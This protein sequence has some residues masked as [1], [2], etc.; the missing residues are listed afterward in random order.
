MTIPIQCDACGKRYRVVEE[1][2]GRR[3]KCKGCGRTLRVPHP[4]ED[5]PEAE[6]ADPSAADAEYSESGQP[7]YRHA[8]REKE[9]RLAQGNEETI[10]AITNHVETHLGAVASVFHEIVSDLVHVDVFYVSATDD[11]PYHTL[12][13]SGM[14]DL[15]MTVPEGAEEFR[16]AELLLSLPPSWPLTQEDFEDERN[17]WPIRWLKMLARLPHEYDTWLGYG[18]TIPNGD[19]PR[20][21]A[22]DTKLCCQLLLLPALVPADFLTLQTA[23]RTIHFYALVPLYREEME[24]KLRHGTEELEE[25]LRRQDVTE[26]LDVKRPNVCKGRP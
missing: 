3:V 7:I 8:P 10:K 6:P 24:F 14:S 11:K 25:L 15:P 5:P 21:F 1:L 2:A 12:V 26:L 4:G 19:P 9:F 23:D 16:H 18:H 17:Y 22:P 13:T 20:P